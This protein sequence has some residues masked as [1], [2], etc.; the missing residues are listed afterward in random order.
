[1]MSIR[2]RCLIAIYGHVPD[3]RFWNADRLFQ[4]ILGV[5]DELK[6]R[7]DCSGINNMEEELKRL[8][9]ENEALKKFKKAKDSFNYLVRYLGIKND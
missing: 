4:D 5:I 9:R 6:G 8:R 3:T 1:M 7:C 2:E